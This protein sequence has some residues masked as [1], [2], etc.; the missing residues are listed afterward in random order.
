MCSQSSSKDNWT[1]GCSHNEEGNDF[2][3]P[4][5]HGIFQHALRSITNFGKTQV[6]QASLNT[7]IAEI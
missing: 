1:H 6:F 7:R 3:G 4:K 5:L 2:G